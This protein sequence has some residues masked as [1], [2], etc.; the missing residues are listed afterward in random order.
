MEK[1]QKAPSAD[2]GMLIRRPV[3]EVFEAFINPDITTKFWFTKSSGRLEK[4]KKVTW[5]WEMYDVN[6]DVIVKDIVPN[7]K[8]E[9]EWGGAGEDMTRVEWSFEPFG[10]VATFVNIVMDGF[11]GD[12][13]SVL[14]QVSGSVG[15][16]CWVLAGLKAYLE[17]NILLNVIADRF[18][19]GKG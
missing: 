4:G 9:I 13:E 19:K 2:T 11:K 1:Q 14:Q 16:F 5:T 18:P 6:A 17:H 3:A 10:D 7:K 12:A 8:I 15:G